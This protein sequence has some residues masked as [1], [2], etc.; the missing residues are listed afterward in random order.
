MPI[1]GRPEGRRL[2]KAGGEYTTDEVVELEQP[3]PY[4]EP[5][6]AE[7]GEPWGWTKD[8]PRPRGWRK[9]G[10]YGTD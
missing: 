10:R 4:P 6:V 2:I 9:D 1:R 5:P 7:Q 8:G 3:E